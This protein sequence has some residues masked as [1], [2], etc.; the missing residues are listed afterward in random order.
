[1]TASSMICSAS[2][3]S[4]SPWK[5]SGW[6]FKVAS[7]RT[8]STTARLP[9][10]G[11]IRSGSPWRTSSGTVSSSAT[12]M[13]RSIWAGDFQSLIEVLDP[14]VVFRVDAGPRTGL[15]PALL[16]GAQDVAEHAVAQGPRFAKLCKPALVNGAAGIIATNRAGVQAVVGM[17]VRGEAITEIDLI[18][19]PGKL[20]KVTIDR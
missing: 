14:D 10:K 6:M 11:L 20:A 12:A 1:M 18:L 16:T 4:S 17:T 2:G 15:A 5:T 13:T 8:L 3:S 7:P 19:D 9:L